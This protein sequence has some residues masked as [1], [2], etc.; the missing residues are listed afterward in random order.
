V[1]A[2]SKVNVGVRFVV[3]PEGP[4]VIEVTGSSSDAEAAD[5]RARASASTAQNAVRARAGFLRR[6]VISWSLIKTALGPGF[7]CPESGHLRDCLRGSQPQPCGDR[8]V[9]A[10]GL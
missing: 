10:A 5:G 9:A 7:P 6:G 4:P 3:D 2:D 1:S 8:K